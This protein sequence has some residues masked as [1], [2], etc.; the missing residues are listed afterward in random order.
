MVLCDAELIKQ[1]RNARREQEGSQVNGSLFWVNEIECRPGILLRGDCNARRFESSNWST[2]WDTQNSINSKLSTP[3]ESTN[4]Q[5]FPYPPRLLLSF[6]SCDKHSTRMSLIS[7][8]RSQAPGW[9]HPR[10]SAESDLFMFDSETSEGSEE[11]IY[12]KPTC[13]GRNKSLYNNPKLEH[14]ISIYCKS[15]RFR[16][17]Q[18]HQSQINPHGNVRQFYDI[19]IV[20]IRK[21]P[22]KRHTRVRN[23]VEHVFSG[24]RPM[25]KCSHDSR[26]YLSDLCPTAHSF[27]AL[28]GCPLGLRHSERNLWLNWLTSLHKSALDVIAHSINRP[29]ERCRH[30]LLWLFYL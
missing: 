29:R 15:I 7:P 12:A 2:K 23:H 24:R 21:K 30:R 19:N 25:Q 11:R 5:T 1:I 20:C 17:S 18:N 16:A 10:A 27:G 3:L 4:I 8:R 26:E 22:I 9:H 6:K 28:A 13:S 14:K